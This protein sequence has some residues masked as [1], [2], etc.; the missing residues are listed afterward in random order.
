M[1]KEK[2]KIVFRKEKLSSDEIMPYKNFA[3]VLTTHQ[4]SKRRLLW[5]RLSA[6]AAGVLLFVMLGWGWLYLSPK[7]QISTIEAQ[8]SLSFPTVLVKEED[9]AQAF[10]SS[11][12]PATENYKSRGQQQIAF[13]TTV[14]E[15][16]AEPNGGLE[17]LKKDLIHT[18]LSCNAKEGLQ[19][20]SFV[21]DEQG[22]LEKVSTSEAYCT[23][24]VM[25]F[26][27]DYEWQ[28][29]QMQGIK[30]RQRIVLAI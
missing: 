3:K 16:N 5:V 22:R 23:E 1:D 18:N 2:N 26:L 8:K 29:A 15:Q 24:K 6:V 12:T 20:L 4:N 9:W 10:V 27:Q 30:L 19:F 13:R 21:I 17:N 7:P 28:P 11:G 25:Q 14:L